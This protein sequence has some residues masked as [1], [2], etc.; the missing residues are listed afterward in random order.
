MLI[1]KNG[2]IVAERYAED[3]DSSSL[4]TSWSVAKSVTSALVGAAR[5]SGD[6]KGLAEPLSNYFGTWAD[7]PKSA[8]TVEHLLTVK[9]GLELLGDEDGDG[10]P[11][12][13]DLYLAAD[14]VALSLS[15]ELIGTPGEQLHIYS[16]S[17]VML[18]GELV[19]QATGQSPAEYGTTVSR[20]N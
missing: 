14:Q 6:I 7:T 8:I 20:I 15:R 19:R 1:I 13:N 3:R 18:A 12:G 2:A 10:V 11:D 17:D 16:N 5:E 9:T 4:V